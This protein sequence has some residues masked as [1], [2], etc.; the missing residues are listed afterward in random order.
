MLTAEQIL[1][2]QYISVTPETTVGK[3]IEQMIEDKTSILLVVSAANQ[4]VGTLEDGVAL[5][6][7]IDAHLR[8]DPVSLH[9]SRQFAS[10]SKVA[11]LDVVLD[12]FVLH[13]LHF[14]PVVD[15]NGF[16]AGVI[17]RAD[18]LHAVFGSATALMGQ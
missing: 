18:L 9:T 15:R 3:A 17:S 6:A 14:L 8:Q 12:Q 16:V 7:A 5:R 13:D 4:L 2:D 11:P 10:V 1:S